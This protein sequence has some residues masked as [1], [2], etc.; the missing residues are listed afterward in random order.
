MTCAYGSLLMSIS[1][2]DRKIH[3]ARLLTEKSQPAQPRLIEGEKEKTLKTFNRNRTICK[4]LPSLCESYIIR[5][6]HILSAFDS[7]EMKTPWK[8]LPLMC[9]LIEINNFNFKLNS[10]NTNVWLEKWP[11]SVG[12]LCAPS[13]LVTR[14]GFRSIYP[15]KWLISIKIHARILRWANIFWL[16]E[17]LRLIFILFFPF[18][19]C[20][21]R[22]EKWE[23]TLAISTC[24]NSVREAKNNKMWEKKQRH[25]T[26][27]INKK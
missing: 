7:P 25:Q 19:L 17:C 18:F 2:A 23:K 16:R 27:K 20:L 26:Q 21:K 6:S 14:V 12:V 15:I 22:G 1:A 24:R 3:L 13:E 10:I 8:S 11:R 4:E 5:V 9:V